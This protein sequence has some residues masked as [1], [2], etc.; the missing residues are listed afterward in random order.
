MEK[1]KRA[2]LS[3]SDKTDIVKLA[4]VL[5]QLGIEIISTGGTA[6]LLQE[7]KIDVKTISSFTNYPEIMDGRV[8][9]LH[10]VIAGGILGLRDQH[11]KEALGANIKWIDLVVCN[12]YPFQQASN[13]ESL[14]EEEIVEQIDIGG[15]TLIRS[16]AKNFKW[17]TVVTEVDS[18][19]NLIEQLL[20][21]QSVSLEKRRE[22]A[23][24]AFAHSAHYDSFIANYFNKELFPKEITIQ[25]TKEDIDLRYGE[26][27]HQKAAVYKGFSFNESFSLLD[28]KTLQ[29]KAL[30][31]NNFNDTYAAIDSVREFNSSA[32]VVIKHATI[33]GVATSITIDDALQKAFEADSLSAYG[34]IIALNKECDAK[35]ATYLSNKFI[36]VLAAPSFTNEALAI[37]SK[38]KNLRLIETGVL[39]PQTS[40]L[41][42]KFIGSDLL[43]QEK[44]TSQ[45]KVEDLKVVTKREPTEK[46]LEDLLFSWSVVKHVKSNAIVT[47]KDLVTC[48]IGSG[49]VSRVDA[50]KIALTKSGDKKG[51]VLASDAFF[52]FRDSIDNIPKGIVSAIIQPGGSIRDEEV[53][54]A[55][56]EANIAM[57]FTNV[58]TFYHG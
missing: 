51:M 17:T 12:L 7:S 33:C 21:N 24:K 4:K 47:V 36:E 5:N 55:C 25:L 43:L 28:S 2:L 11:Q 56:D 16:A 53:I 29:G 58:R 1:I 54:A 19:S 38:K 31:F 46:E 30:S 40:A 22:F 26:N 15:V 49:Q 8:K 14:S 57:L 20:E 27:P 13:D 23:S 50:T 41:V 52:P 18:Y 3:V 32:A 34:S 45:L 6:K 42:G 10:P 35:S 39:L 44:E 48:G 9:T 37:F